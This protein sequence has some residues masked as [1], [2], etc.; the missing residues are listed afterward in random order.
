[1]T[2]PTI[3][4]RTTREV[5]PGVQ[6]IARPLRDSSPWQRWKQRTRMPQGHP[7]LLAPGGS[8]RLVVLFLRR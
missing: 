7:S 8:H 6:D 5:S 2:A 1:M 4:H 3:H